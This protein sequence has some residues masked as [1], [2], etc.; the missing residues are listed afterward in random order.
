MDLAAREFNL[1]LRRTAN[2]SELSLHLAVTV[3]REIWQSFKLKLRHFN[4]H[5]DTVTFIMTN[6]TTYSIVFSIVDVSGGQVEK[7]M[8]TENLKIM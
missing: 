6:S 3:F 1:K 2:T 7:S 5:Y 4:K 8:V